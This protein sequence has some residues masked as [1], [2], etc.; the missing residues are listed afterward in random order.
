[1]ENLRKNALFQ[2]TRALE[3]MK[4]MNMDSF[5]SKIKA[6]NWSLNW[7]KLYTWTKHV[8]LLQKFHRF[9]GQEFNFETVCGGD[10]SIDGC[11]LREM[12]QVF[13]DLI[14]KDK[15]PLERDC[16]TYICFNL[17]TS[18]ITSVTGC[19]NESIKNDED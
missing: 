17:G 1:L 13:H 4:K 2:A 19:S 12:M 10:S 5:Y 11:C 3:F 9:V 8:N 18:Q 14:L 16:N 6:D 15:V 7:F